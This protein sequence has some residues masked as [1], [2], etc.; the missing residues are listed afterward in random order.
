MIG[1]LGDAFGQKV[2][3]F[4]DG[5][6]I[7]KIVLRQKA[8]WKNTQKTKYVNLGLF[9]SYS[10]IVLYDKK[11][12]L[13]GNGTPRM[14]KAEMRVSLSAASDGQFVYPVPL[15]V[16]CSKMAEWRLLVQK[17]LMELIGRSFMRTLLKRV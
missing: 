8:S 3:Q 4:Q 6:S 14:R 2:Q 7:R 13:V 16:A 10:L 12:V 9:L 1:M 15:L 11:A 17:S 5:F